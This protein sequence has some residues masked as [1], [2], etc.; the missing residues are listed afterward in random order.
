MLRFMSLVGLPVLIAV[1]WSISS[2]RRRFP[3][4]IV[5]VGLLLQFALALLILKTASGQ[6]FFQHLADLFTA[7]M[8]FVDEGSEFVFGVRPYPDET[9]YP[10]Q[11]LLLRTFAFGVLPKIIFFSSLMAIMYYLGIMQFIVRIMAVCM[12]RALG[13]SGAESLAAA[14]NVIVGQTEAPLLIGPYVQTMTRSELMALMVGGF[15][16]IAGS[17]LAAFH[18]F[19]IDVGHL[20]TASVISAPASLLIAKVMQPE[21][22]RPV[23]LGRV[24]VDVPRNGVNVFD[25]ATSGASDGLRLA[26]NVGAMLIAAIGFIALLNAIVGWCGS[27][28]LHRDDW[29][30]ELFFGWAF[31][32]VAWIMGIESGDCRSAGELLGIKMVVNEFVAYDRLGHFIRL[33]ERSELSGRTI[34]IMTYALSGFAN[35]SSI[36]IQLAGI[37]SIAPDRKGDL[38]RLGLRAM[39]GGTI[40]CCMTACVA[41]VL[42]D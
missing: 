17:V 27:Q 13:T 20:I 40:A 6:Q 23:T 26:L 38:A 34:T 10:P 30:L 3:L 12:Q 5:V 2:A 33:G 31:S 37:G 14:A 25:A 15:A 21:L 41:G 7:L 18:S 42:L 22:D 32:P 39:I 16:T 29:S 24:S 9:G 28:F 19:G 4:R 11:V 1:A 8:G 35:F 36:G